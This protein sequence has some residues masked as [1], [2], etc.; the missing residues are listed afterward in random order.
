MGSLNRNETKVLLNRR[1]LSEQELEDVKYI[2]QTFSQLSRYELA[3]RT[4]SS[5]QSRQKYCLW[6][7]G[8]FL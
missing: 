2:V 7:H 8:K 1:W 5:T 3:R 6:L 4:G